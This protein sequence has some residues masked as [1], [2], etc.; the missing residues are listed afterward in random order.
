MKNSCAKTPMG[1]V[2]NTALTDLGFYSLIVMHAVMDWTYHHMRR[3]KL[4]KVRKK[5]HGREMRR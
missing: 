4:N 1:M 5:P 3:L 2:V